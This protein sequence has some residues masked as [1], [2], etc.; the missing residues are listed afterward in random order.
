MESII[1]PHIVGILLFEGTDKD[2]C[3]DV[4]VNLLAHLCAEDVQHG[5][6]NALVLNITNTKLL[7]KPLI[8][9]VFHGNGNDDNDR[10]EGRQQ[11]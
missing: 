9:I 7:E 3:V 11:L 5:K 10:K 1:V 4:G 8:P 6:P 2:Q